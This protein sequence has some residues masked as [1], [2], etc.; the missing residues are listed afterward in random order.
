MRAPGYPGVTRN[1]QSENGPASEFGNTSLGPIVFQLP[2]LEDIKIPGQRRDLEQI[3][4]W[5]QEGFHPL[6]VLKPRWI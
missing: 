3:R 2:F 4:S 1:Q 5:S 6:S